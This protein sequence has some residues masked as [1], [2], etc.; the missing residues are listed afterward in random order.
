MRFSAWNYFHL[1]RQ[2]AFKQQY[3]LFSAFC[4]EPFAN[5]LHFASIIF[6]SCRGRKPIETSQLF[7]TQNNSRNSTCNCTFLNM[8]LR[9]PIYTPTIFLKPIKDM[10]QHTVFP[11]CTKYSY[12][13]EKKCHVCV[14][15]NRKCNA[16]QTGTD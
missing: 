7:K 11:S 5:K 15:R 10:Q 6:V 8:I 16:L 14:T 12:I 13:T 3:A 1:P 2:F 9:N 4:W